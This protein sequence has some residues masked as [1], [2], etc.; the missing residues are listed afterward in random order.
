MVVFSMKAA[1]A[2]RK[3][4]AA[5]QEANQIQRQQMQLEQ[6]REKRETIRAAR[7]ARGRAINAAA[8]QGSMDSSGA[9]GGTSSIGSQLNYNLSFLDQQGAMADQASAALGRSRLWESRARTAQGMANLTWKIAS[10]G[11]SQGG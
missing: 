3:S 7:I 8:N 6:N 5:A 4:A 11:S 10:F 9:V 1:K 2:Q